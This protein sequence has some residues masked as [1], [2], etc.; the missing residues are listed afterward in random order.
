MLFLH[1]SE[2]LLT[3]TEV[4]TH[5]YIWWNWGLH[6]SLIITGWGR[7][8]LCPDFKTQGLYVGGHFRFNSIL[9]PWPYSSSFLVGQFL[10]R[11]K[12]E[13]ISLVCLHW[14]MLLCQQSYALYSAGSHVHYIFCSRRI[15]GI[16]QYNTRVALQ[17]A[18]RE[19]ISSAVTY[20]LVYIKDLFFISLFVGLTAFFWWTIVWTCQAHKREE[21]SCVS[22]SSFTW[23]IV[24]YALLF[25]FL[26]PADSYPCKWKMLTVTCSCLSKK[27]KIVTCS[28]LFIFRGSLKIFYLI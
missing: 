10:N 18:A 21:H 24:R 19:G 25:L 15:I 6:T 9:M 12:T 11:R 27:K 8:W 23:I 17:A 7:P 20:C 2:F 4:P 14:F 16:Y 13:Y 5:L 3:K 22:C 26:F 1:H 28:F